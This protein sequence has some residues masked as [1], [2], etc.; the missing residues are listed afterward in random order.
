MISKTFVA[1]AR[2]ARI[3][4]LQDNTFE[5]KTQDNKQ[6]ALLGGHTCITLVMGGATVAPHGALYLKISSLHRVKQILSKRYF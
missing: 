6:V 1:T 3:C 5:Q 2:A 4:E